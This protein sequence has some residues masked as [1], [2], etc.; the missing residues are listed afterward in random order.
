VIVLPLEKIMVLDIYENIQIA[1]WAAQPAG[2]SF[3]G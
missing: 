3:A 2:F 1:L